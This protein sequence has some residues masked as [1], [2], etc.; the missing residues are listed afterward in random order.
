MVLLC[1]RVVNWKCLGRLLNHLIELILNPAILQLTLMKKHIP[2][3]NGIFCSSRKIVW[4]CETE[5]K[6]MH[7]KWPNKGSI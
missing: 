5:N 7:K 6:P 1:T 3:S 2:N 4:N